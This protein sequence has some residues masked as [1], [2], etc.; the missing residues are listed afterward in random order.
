MRARYD[1]A[2]VDEDKISSVQYLK[3]AVG[4]GTPVALGCDLPELAEE[5]PLSDEQQAALLADLRS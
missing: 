2:Q 1:Q 4:G 3:F 5:V